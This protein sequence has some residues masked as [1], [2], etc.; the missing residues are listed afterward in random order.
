MC[1]EKEVKM[2][3]SKENVAYQQKRDELIPIAEAVADRQFPKPRKGLSHK[4]MEEWSRLW[5]QTFF[6]EMNDLWRKYE[7]NKAING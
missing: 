4:E 2:K 1:E 7:T 5:N 3:V 6:G